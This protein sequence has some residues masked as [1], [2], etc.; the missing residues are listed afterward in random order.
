MG[1][2]LLERPFV[3]LPPGT[4][5]RAMG[6]TITCLC[7]QNNRCLPILRSTNL[8]FV[9]GQPYRTWLWDL[10]HTG[11]MG[12]ELT[13]LDH[14]WEGGGNDWVGDTPPSPVSLVDLLG[15]LC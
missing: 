15:A 8:D 5:Y 11:M 9:G 2:I 7:K 10:C 6:A 3:R 12:S 13:G 4:T 1:I 14:I